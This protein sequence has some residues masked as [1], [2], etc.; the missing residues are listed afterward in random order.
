[1]SFDSNNSSSISCSNDKKLCKKGCGHPVASGTTRKG[2]PYDPACTERYRQYT[3]EKK[4][5]SNRNSNN[6]TNNSN[7][8]N[9]S[10]SSGFSSIGFGS[11]GFGNS[12]LNNVGF[13]TFSFHHCW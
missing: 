5:D 4:I 13:V 2:N 6:N 7:N 10:N 12:G 8:N 11:S 9:N 3:K 1:M